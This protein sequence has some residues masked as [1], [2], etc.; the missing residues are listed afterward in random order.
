MPGS[1]PAIGEEEDEGE[2]EP[3]E[4]RHLAV[5]SEKQCL[6]PLACFSG[7]HGATDQEIAPVNG[8]ASTEAALL[9]SY[10]RRSIVSNLWVWMCLRCLQVAA[11]R[12]DLVVS[13]RVTTHA[14]KMV[15]R[16]ATS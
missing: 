14:F 15:T 6:H 13:L 5:A 8:T 4:A 16:R 9:P 10:M 12:Q 11:M 2:D 3:E 1:G 7:A